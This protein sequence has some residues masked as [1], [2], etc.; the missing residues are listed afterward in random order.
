M[1]MRKKGFSLIEL[2]IVLVIIGML[3]GFIFPAAKKARDAALQRQCANNLN[4]IGTAL[5]LYAKDHHGSFPDPV[6]GNAWC[7]YR[8]YLIAQ[9]YL[10]DDDRLFDCPSLPTVGTADS[11]DYWYG[12]TANEYDKTG[13]LGPINLDYP[14][15][16]YTPSW[17]IL[18]GCNNLGNAPEYDGPHT[19]GSNY[20]N[21]A[22]RVYWEADN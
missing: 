21:I 1:I 17:R 13:G 22:G 15:T 12:N 6:S 11:P 2:M 3:I 14:Y 10:P 7:V 9:D 18:C 16:V 8:D 20:V 19:K 5:I 4:Q